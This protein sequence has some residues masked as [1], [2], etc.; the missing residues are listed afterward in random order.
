[1]VKNNITRFR[2]RTKKIRACSKNAFRFSVCENA[3]KV[4]K[5]M[6]F[7]EKSY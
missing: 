1:M 3:E 6:R 7:F 5:K 2:F 4:F